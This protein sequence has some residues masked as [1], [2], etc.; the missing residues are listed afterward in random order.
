M[1][2]LER[3][4]RIP[5]FREN[6]YVRKKCRS[7]GSA[8]WTKNGDQEFC[9]DS[10]CVEYS[11]IN[12][13]ITP[14]KFS[15]D[16]MREAFLSFFEK[17]GHRRIP[18]YPVIARWRNDIFL[19]IASIA[20][21]QPHVTSGECDPPANPL[22]IS[23]PCIRL[24][25][26]DS[27]G[28]SGRHLTN[29]EM[30][31]HHAFNYGRK[32]I[33]WINETVEYCNN[34]LQGI[35]VNT[36]LVTYKE[37]PWSG[38]GN[39][40]PA[41]EVLT[42][43]LEIVTLVFMNLK[44]AGE[45]DSNTVVVDGEKYAPMG[46]RI[47]DTGYGLE[48][49]AWASQGTPTIYDAV[50]GGMVNDLMKMKN[51]DPED[52]LTGEIIGESARLSGSMSVNSRTN[53]SRFREECA[54]KLSKKGYDVSV[55]EINSIMNPLEGIYALCDHTKCMA[56]MLGDGIVPSNS[57]AGYLARLMIRQ[58]YRILEE[59]HINVDLNDLVARHLED[60]PRYSGDEGRI[61]D[62]LTLEKQRY[63][64]TLE[65]GVAM[66]K[67]EAKND[68]TLNDLMRFYDTY[69]VPPEVVKRISDVSIPD[70]FYSLIAQ[71]HSGE[72]EKIGKG[73]ERSYPL[74]PT[75]LLF[76]KE[77]LKYGFTGKV[78]LRD[79]NA[80]ILDKT[81]FYPE[82][83]GQPSDVGKVTGKGGEVE[84]VH[85]EKLANGVVLHHLKEPLDVGIGDV[86]EGVVDQ[87]RRRTLEKNHTA[88]H[89][90]LAS[91]RELFG[92]HIWQHGAQKG[93]DRSRLDITHY[94]RISREEL[95]WI[96]RRS[97][98]IIDENIEISAR[99]MKRKDAEAEYGFVL[100]EGGVVSGNVIRVV[101]IDGIDSQACAGT[102]CR[103]TGEIGWVKILK[104][105][106]IQDGV[107]R[108]EFSVAGSALK[109]FEE[110]ETLVDRV[111]AA[112]NTREE[113]LEKSVEKILK[114]WRELK[115]ENEKL[116][117]HIIDGRKKSLILEG[118]GTRIVKDLNIL[119]PKS[120]VKEAAALAE[121]EGI[122]AIVGNTS[123][124][125][126]MAR[127]E[128]VDINSSEIL[129]ELKKFGGKGGGKANLAQGSVKE[130]DVKKAL[131]FLE[132]V[133]KLKLMEDRFL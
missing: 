46:V 107:E 72:S 87:K 82:G 130:K 31:A 16:E 132:D 83:G 19:T 37:N 68:I 102:H 131:D 52:E 48:R 51:I 115:K 70:N 30:M 23:Q 84:V 34:F 124:N 101:S 44:Y 73:E 63:M 15:V 76:Y 3:A 120:L 57:R 75:E 55:E 96:E 58:S 93:L 66:V 108:I 79:G 11:F 64:E 33:Y 60:M 77:P 50:Y 41:L 7:C 104:T 49:L 126:A 98:E 114:E 99:F 97:N 62:I 6:G 118:D 88:T 5:F 122:I 45:G 112:L 111:C 94:R 116:V 14:K 10:P 47:V 71:M 74:K 42:R 53:I 103:R 39:A 90:I 86:V 119:S 29:F 13:P 61:L 36:D 100:Y 89:L 28:K 17:N 81:L 110:K 92:K 22:T 105:E 59:L 4:Y 123:G 1:V 21:F 35:G 95:E 106:R 85:V 20:D 67:R 12:N 24:N 56:L 91:A 38:G 43:G 133:T 54:R 127:N 80:L 65:K 109:A 32:K 27:V 117:D 69:G 121:K 113:H 125:V 129:G 25:D 9:G 128:K 8:F 26:L 2:D 78:L 40:G 18:P